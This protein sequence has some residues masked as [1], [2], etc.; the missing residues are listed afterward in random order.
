MVRGDGVV[1]CVRSL[2]A[3][4]LSFQGMMCSTPGRR[5]SRTSSVGDVAEGVFGGDCVDV[6]LQFVSLG[7]VFGRWRRRRW[8]F[9]SR[10]CASCRRVLVEAIDDALEVSAGGVCFAGRPGEQEFDFAVERFGGG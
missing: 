7:D 4:V 9:C 5:K 3:A 1:Y 10:R 6:K 8:W 2:R